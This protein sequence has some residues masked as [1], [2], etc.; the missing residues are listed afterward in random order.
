MGFLLLVLSFGFFNIKTGDFT[1]DE[2]KLKKALFLVKRK[3]L[4]ML[5]VSKLNGCTIN[6]CLT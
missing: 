1:F 2:I 4:M 5:P 6:Y 3:G